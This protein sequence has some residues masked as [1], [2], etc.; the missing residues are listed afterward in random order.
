MTEITQGLVLQAS[1]VNVH[2][3]TEVTLIMFSSIVSKSFFNTV[4]E[5]RK[6]Q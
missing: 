5:K 3:T 4:G 1:E 2:S 6:R